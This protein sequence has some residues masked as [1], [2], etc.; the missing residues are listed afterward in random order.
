M[1]KISIVVSFAVLLLLLPAQSA[2]AWGPGVHMAI[3]EFFLNNLALLSPVV[4][5]ILASHGD[6]FLY[7]CLSPDIFVGKGSRPRPGHS[8][9]WSVA[10]GILQQA[11]S[12]EVQAYAL[13]YMSHLAADT[14]AHNYYVPNLVSAM[15]LGGTLPHVYAELLAD[16]YVLWSPR[17][18][19]RLMRKEHKAE[20]RAL[21][22]SIRRQQPLR[23]LS[24]SL[25]K[26]LVGDSMHL[27]NNK[28]VDGSLRL[29]SKHLA[30]H[31]LRFYFCNQMEISIATVHDLL[32]H[33]ES[34]PSR[35]LDPIG[36]DALARAKNLLLQKRFAN[37]RGMLTPLGN[38]FPVDPRLVS[39][40]R[41][42][43]LEADN[44]NILRQAHRR[45]ESTGSH[46]A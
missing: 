45:Y 8:H 10:Q 26:R 12:T 36:A 38:R 41:P 6:S 37:L 17:K 18:A 46:A 43:L 5:G 2:F 32:L 3:G 29:L 34:C 11:K 7:G 35:Q 20:D 16:N 14:V 39:L 44:L 27:S 40:P 13:G 19:R 1:S 15:P 25:K 31:G 21:F 9:N 22:R 23:P 42:L 4:A 30:P 24:F 33:P 28:G